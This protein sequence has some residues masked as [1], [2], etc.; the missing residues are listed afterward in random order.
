M[1]EVK[2]KEEKKKVETVPIEEV[3]Q[4]ISSTQEGQLFLKY[5]HD[6]CGFARTDSRYNPEAGEM[7]PYATVHCAAIRGLYVDIRRHIPLNKLLV[8]EH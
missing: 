3:V 2:K 1:A 8:I 6:Y 7:N 5:L 4:K